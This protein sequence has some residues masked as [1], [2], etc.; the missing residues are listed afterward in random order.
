[1]AAFTADGCVIAVCVCQLV[2]FLQLFGLYFYKG[3]CVGLSLSRATRKAMS[4]FF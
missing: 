4:E 3:M 1:M 2:M